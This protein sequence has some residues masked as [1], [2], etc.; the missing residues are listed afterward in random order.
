MA[1]NTIAVTTGTNLILSDWLVSAEAAADFKVQKTTD[2]VSFF[3]VL[4]WRQP[5][6][7]TGG[8]TELGIAVSVTGGANVALR[9]RV[10][11][12]GGATNVTTTL[13]SYT[14]P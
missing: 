14:E 12:P 5:S 10:T 13:R 3:D 11:T 6:D 7:G 8:I 1:A 2:G 9:V 4:I